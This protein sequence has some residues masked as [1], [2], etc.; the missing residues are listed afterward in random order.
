MENI[1]KTPSKNLLYLRFD[2]FLPVEVG[3]L[4]SL[5]YRHLKPIWKTNRF[6]ST[7][8]DP[9]PVF[10]GHP[11]PGKYRIRI[12]VEIWADYI[13]IKSVLHGDLSLFTYP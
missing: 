2:W 12:T 10:L 8:A 11:D 1:Y 13:P 7:V 4:G 6:I 5:F 3:V 9:D